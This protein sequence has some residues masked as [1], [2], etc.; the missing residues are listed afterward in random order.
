MS[1][2]LE[3][4]K[5]YKQKYLNTKKMMSGGSIF[6]IK[7][8]EQ[9]YPVKKIFNTDGTVS[10][11]QEISR[12]PFSPTTFNS[13]DK[14]II[15]LFLHIVMPC[16]IING[17]QISPTIADT[18]EY[19]A[20]G[21]FGATISIDKYIIK[22]TNIDHT[23]IE[24]IQYMAE[25]GSNFPNRFCPLYCATIF[26]L[27]FPQ[28]LTSQENHKNLF[29]IMC[30]N[31]TKIDKNMF[32]ENIS[33]IQSDILQP[34]HS[35][36][37]C[38]MVME[39]GQRDVFSFVYE[40]SH[41]DMRQFIDYTQINSIVYNDEQ[42][43]FTPADK[44]NK[45]YI[46]F[47][48]NFVYNLLEAVYILNINYKIMHCDIRLMNILMSYH[49]VNKYPAYKLIDFGMVTY[50]SDMNSF[51]TP[52][53]NIQISSLAGLNLFTTIDGK[54]CYTILF[55]LYRSFIAFMHFIGLLAHK[56]DRL[57]HNFELINVDNKQTGI[58]LELS[59]ELHIL[60]TIIK[61]YLKY[62][63]EISEPSLKRKFACCIN[64]MIV[65]A[66]IPKILSS[67]NNMVYYCPKPYENL[68]DISSLTKSRQITSTAPIQTFFEIITEILA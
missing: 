9:Y 31:N 43:I 17:L 25:L 4:Y 48:I 46:I 34:S 52:T 51:Y 42:F 55:D 50:I 41:M 23:K 36:K 19:L 39:K 26:N 11:I 68:V 40:S 29:N 59:S 24:E 22:I 13:S 18:A 53:S 58:Y 35:S 3:K 27:D 37:L 60:N 21:S 5:K 14:N 64:T 65:L 45:S 2:Y 8:N 16:L 28:T 66:Q 6:F 54:Q 44:I 38:F 10:F 15:E 63:L 30:F 32:D 1:D 67:S 49:D 47:F 7:N 12:P 20:C 62:A 57:K 61:Y 56:S 33:A